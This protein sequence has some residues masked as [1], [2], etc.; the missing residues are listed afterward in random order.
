V[1]WRF[2]Q[3]QVTEGKIEG[4]RIRRRRLKQLLDDLKE[5]RRYWHLNVGVLD[6]NFWTTRWKRTYTCP[7]VQIC[8]YARVMYAGRWT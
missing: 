8:Y 2:N 7:L 6:R 1:I 4:M 5:D 3:N